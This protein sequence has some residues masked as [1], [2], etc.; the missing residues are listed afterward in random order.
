M[1]PDFRTVRQPVPCNRRGTR[2]KGGDQTVA[3]TRC[4]LSSGFEDFV[5]ELLFVDKPALGSLQNYNLVSFQTA[6]PPKSVS[7]PYTVFSLNL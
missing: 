5:V 4:V 2:S 6:A 1:F 3:P 7:P